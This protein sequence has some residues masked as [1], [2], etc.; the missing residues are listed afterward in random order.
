[1]NMLFNNAGEWMREDNTYTKEGFQVS[2]VLGAQSC[3]CKIGK[4]TMVPVWGTI[5]Q[6]SLER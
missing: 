3:L 5:M 6:L 2:W 1:M 4:V